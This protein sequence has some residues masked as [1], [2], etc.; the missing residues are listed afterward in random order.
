MPFIP[1]NPILPSDP[2]LR[3]RMYREQRALLM[4]Q[5]AAHGESA[6]FGVWLVIAAI[7][8]VA[9]GLLIVVEQIVSR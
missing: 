8:M 2:V 4:R 9:F 3:E 5:A 1:P 7:G 6:R